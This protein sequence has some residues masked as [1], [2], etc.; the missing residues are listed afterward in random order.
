MLFFFQ[1]SV[2]S[3]KCCFQISLFFQ[4][5]CSVEDQSLLLGAPI[6]VDEEVPEIPTKIITEEQSFQIKGSVLCFDFSASTNGHF[7]RHFITYMQP[8]NLIL[9]NGTTES[10]RIYSEVVKG[11]LRNTG[12]VFCPDKEQRIEILDQLD[13]F[14]V[15]MEKELVQNL[16][17]KNSGL[18]EVAW[19]EGELQISAEEPSMIKM[20]PCKTEIPRSGKKTGLFAG[21]CRLSTIKKKMESVGMKTV[22]QEGKLVCNGMIQ[23]QVLE[24]SRIAIEGP[25]CTDYYLIRQAIDELYKLN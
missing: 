22:F 15:V 11:V 14:G 21:D 13:C 2:F 4:K 20:I 25:L 12:R 23:I 17:W 16:E 18:T 10:H 3:P 8:R 19:I 6:L 24:N 9:I 5:F 1:N 7:M